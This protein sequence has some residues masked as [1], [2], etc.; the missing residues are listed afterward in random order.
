MIRFCV[1]CG[2]E[3]PTRYA[4]AMFCSKACSMRTWRARAMLAGTHGYVNHQFVRVK[5]PA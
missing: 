4:A 3:F 5:P 2:H 1:Q